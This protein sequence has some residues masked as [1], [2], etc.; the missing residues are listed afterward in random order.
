MKVSLKALACTAMVSI[1]FLAC[2]DISANNPDSVNSGQSEEIYGQSGEMIKGQS[3]SLEDLIALGISYDPLAVAIDPAVREWMEEQ[4]ASGSNEKIEVTIGERHWEYSMDYYEA[5]RLG[6]KEEYIKSESPKR[7]LPIPGIIESYE[8]Y[9]TALMT[10]EEIAKL[11][12]DYTEL[13]I[14]AS[15]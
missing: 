3:F 2:E 8:R 4:I 12:E 14:W 1:A 10:A 15:F 7:D 9:W 13:L 11:A 5:E 6:L